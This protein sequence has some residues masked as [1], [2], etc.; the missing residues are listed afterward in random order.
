MFN[1]LIVS[2]VKTV[3]NVCKLLQLLGTS[4]LDPTSGLPSPDLLGYSP[5]MKIAGAASIYTRVQFCGKALFHCLELYDAPRVLLVFQSQP[6]W[7]I[8]SCY[9][10]DILFNSYFIKMFI[11][12]FYLN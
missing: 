3:N 8:L 5:Q 12:L 10:S 2:A 11:Y 1:I 6:I 4:P 9:I 7:K